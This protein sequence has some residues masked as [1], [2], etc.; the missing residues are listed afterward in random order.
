M[1]AELLDTPTA[2]DRLRILL[3]TPRVWY[4]VNTGG[5][6]RSS[7]LFEALAR[8][9]EISA[10][11]FQ[12]ADDRLEDL[13]QMRSWC[14]D[15]EVVPWRETRRFSPA[16]FV[17][18]AR[19]VFSRRPYTV[20]KY[21]SAAMAS[22]LA[23]RLASRRFDVLVCDFLEPGINCLSL[24]FRPKVLFQ[25]NVEATIRERQAAWAANPL[26]RLYAR[27]D[28]VK[29]KD[30]EGRIAR[31]FD[32]CIMVSEADCQ[33]MTREYGVTNVAAIPIAVDTRHFA[34][35]GASAEK[36]NELVFV[37]SMD[38]HP[39]QDAV[40][41]FVRDIL[42]KVRREVPATLTIVG[43][44]PPPSIQRLADIP[45]IVVTGTVPDV[46]PY[47]AR[48]QLCVVPLRVGGGTRIK[49]FEA[50]AM[51]TAVVS[52]P[53][54]A[55]GLPVSDG[56]NIALA[57]DA[58]AF[59]ATLVRLLRN[60]DERRQLATAGRRL[61]GEGYSWDAAAQR[62][63]AICLAIVRQSRSTP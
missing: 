33:T 17:E 31:A 10:I 23:A 7:R 26:L 18:L 43:R 27:R 19:S 22:R 47:L 41:F 51:G 9:H 48:A 34:P 42:P 1:H 30:Y 45:G 25:H 36:P 52:T 16:F 46:R 44:H 12:T 35:I 49:I 60:P 58:D 2:D 28:A 13:E 3:L 62:F 32:C 40:S 15:L 57:A 5:R 63:S 50:M 6:I 37:G 24:D 39:N 55:E 21:D 53:L 4:P 56:T 14:R 20:L 61:V 38:W 59:A 8:R 29:L 54:G 11:C